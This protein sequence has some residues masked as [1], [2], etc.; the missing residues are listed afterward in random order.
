MNIFKHHLLLCAVMLMTVFVQS[1]AVAQEVVDLGLPSGKLWADRNVG[2]TDPCNCGD[3]VAYGDSY[4]GPFFQGLTEFSWEEYR[5][6][7]GKETL[8]VSKYGNNP[9]QRKLDAKND[10]ATFKCGE[11]WY[12]PTREDFMELLDNCDIKIVRNYNNTGR[13]GLLVYNRKDRSQFIFIPGCGIVKGQKLINS[14]ID[15]SGIV[16]LW[17]STTDVKHVARQAYTF[18]ADDGNGGGGKAYGTFYEED[19]CLGMTVRP[20]RNKMPEAAGTTAG[21]EGKPVDLGLPSGTLWADHNVGASSP[22]DYGNYYAWGE[23]ST[24]SSYMGHK[25]CKDYLKLTKYCSKSDE[26][27]NGFTDRR[28]TLEPND[29]VAT[30]KWGDK[31]CMPTQAQ[32][33]EL[34]EEC[35]WTWTTRGGHNGYDIKGPNGNSI[36]LPAA[37]RKQIDDMDDEGE[38]GYYWSSSLYINMPS[39]ASSLEIESDFVD[40]D[41][42]GSRDDGY[43]VRPVRRKN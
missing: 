23:T 35:T 7:N 25:W 26:G 19:Y 8:Q 38:V 30:S 14:D 12:T 42:S 15:K 43:T 18:Y 9:N 34:E 31:W 16:K 2:A 37:G 5:Y 41:S 3:Y 17:T 24:K 4:G 32:M 10:A 11:E 27:Y 39:N 40:S 1:N 28:T 33:E 29:D 22:E 20:I 21:T 36:F 13:R 6:A